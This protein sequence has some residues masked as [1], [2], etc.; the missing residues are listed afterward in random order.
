MS[1]P[2]GILE[3]VLRL[4]ENN[5]AEPSDVAALDIQISKR[6]KVMAAL[7]PIEADASVGIQ[8]EI[9]ELERQ[10]AM[11]RAISGPYRKFRL[12]E[13]LRWR[14]PDGNPKLVVFGMDHPEM[15]FE[16]FYSGDGWQRDYSVVRPNLPRVMEACYSDV[17][18]NLYLEARKRSAG[19]EIWE[20]R[21][22]MRLTAKFS[23]LIPGEFKDKIQTAKK[24]FDSQVYLVAEAPKWELN[25]EVSIANR[26]PLVIGVLE[27]EIFYITKFD[28]TNLENLLTSEYLE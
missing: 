2:V 27:N 8:A 16:A 25:E 7:L 6:R 12:A 24:D 21:C 5:K 22:L 3:E 26:D 28:P 14:R 20:K 23:G 18:E 13:A 19:K 4:V 11:A 10:R 1:E 17:R 15:Q 9:N